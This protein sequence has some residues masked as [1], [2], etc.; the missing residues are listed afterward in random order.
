MNPIDIVMVTYSR[1]DFTEQTLIHLNNRTKHP[2]RLFVVDNAST[3]GTSD[4]LD[5]YQKKG[6]IYR[7]VRLN[8]NVGIHMAWNIGMAMTNS[9]LFITTDNDILVPDLQ[10]CWLEQMVGLMKLNPDYAAIALQP[11]IFVGAKNVPT[12]C[13]EDVLHRNMCGAV[14]RIMRRDIV[15]KA[16]GWA[17]DY[18]RLRNNEERHICAALQGLGHKVGY[19]GKL[20]SFHLF[21]DETTDPWGY[22]K[23]ATPE[24]HGHRDIWPPVNVYGKKE[25]YDNKTWF[26][27]EK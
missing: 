17:H 27:K 9:K 14:M 5:M 6:V 10:P 23:G 13:K 16:G 2:Y 25:K 18:N 26:P 21:G 20:R 22:K 19:A 12:D 11:H 4:I 8:E 15:N 7:W 3:D 24:S 1:K